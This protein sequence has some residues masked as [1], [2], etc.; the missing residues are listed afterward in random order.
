MSRIVSF[1]V[2][3]AILLVM[4]A[5]FFQVMASFLLPMFLAV[6]LVI[7]FGPLHRWVVAKCKGRIR[8]AAGLTTAAILLI[9]LIPV[10]LILVP[11]TVQGFG[12]Y[13]GQ[14]F[15]QF[16]PAGLAK[17]SVDAAGRLGVH[18]DEQDVRKLIIEKTQQWLAPLALSTTQYLGRTLIG[19][20]V[21][22]ISLYYFL[23]DGPGMV[24]TIMRLS[25]LDDKYEEQLIEQF[26]TM[27]RAVVVATVL[28]AFVQGVLAGIGFAVAGVGYVYLLTALAMLF[29][30]VPF[31]GTTIV[32][33][34]ACLWLYFS[35]DGSTVAAVFLAIYCGGVV[36]LADNVI[37][38]LVLHGRSNLHPLLA[39]LSVLG[40]V[41]ALGPIGIFVGP[42]VVAFL[43]TL[44]NMLHTELDAMGKP[45][46][47]DDARPAF[48][49]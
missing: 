24:R 21:M 41:Q 16:N 32:W 11:A 30:M 6:L 26:D 46:K 43:Q 18:L 20:G 33:V 29:A 37:K 12:I 10:L 19:L 8:L 28:S 9:L 47:A 49:P 22:I 14:D 42:M 23:A 5:L 15:S 2:L 7:M 27:T 44:L 39:L 13:N 25:P 4:A 1:V 17:A 45:L 38:P 3:V 34:P 35:P 36:S 40:G 31:V 48:P